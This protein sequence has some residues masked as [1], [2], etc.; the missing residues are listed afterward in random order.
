MIINI[1]L[2]VQMNQVLK[3]LNYLDFVLTKLLTIYVENQNFTLAYL[4]CLPLALDE[5]QIYSPFVVNVLTTVI[6][7]NLSHSRNFIFHRKL[8]AQISLFGYF[9]TADTAPI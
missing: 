9:S 7:Y 6:L 2:T 8:E 4:H 3:Q 1:N 5:C